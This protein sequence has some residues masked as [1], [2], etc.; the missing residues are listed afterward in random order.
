MMETIFEFGFG[1][2]LFVLFYRGFKGKWPW[3][4]NEH[5]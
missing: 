4:R 2:M 5:R 3:V 1:A